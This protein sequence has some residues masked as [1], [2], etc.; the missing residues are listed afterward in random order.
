MLLNLGYVSISFG[1]GGIATGLL[2]K[3]GWIPPVIDTGFI[4]ELLIAAIIS[5]IALVMLRTTFNR[6]TSDDINQ[7]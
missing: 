3:T 7:Y 5:V 1:L 2:V 4:D 6:K